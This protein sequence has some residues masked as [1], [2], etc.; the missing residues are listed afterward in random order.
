MLSICNTKFN[1]EI[2]F[3]MC[4]FLFSF[5]FKKDSSMAALNI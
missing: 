5:Q 2:I 4:S 1:F 3:I